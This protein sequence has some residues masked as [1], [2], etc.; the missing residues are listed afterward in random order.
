MLC[1]H[2]L[3]KLRNRPRGRR[4]KTRP[5]SPSSRI[6]CDSAG[7]DSCTSEISAC[8]VEK[9][10]SK[11]SPLYVKPEFKQG[12]QVLA[13]RPQFRYNPRPARSK[14]KSANRRRRSDSNSYSNDSDSNSNDSNRGRTFLKLANR[15]YMHRAVHVSYCSFRSFFPYKQ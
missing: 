8:S 11:Y 6:R 9:V 12:K 4:R 13:T 3:P 5:D 15:K 2:L 10:Y 7:S 1:N 14:A